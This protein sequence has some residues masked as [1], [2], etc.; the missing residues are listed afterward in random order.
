M[1]EPST[2][3]EWAPHPRRDTPRALALARELDAPLAAAHVLVNRGLCDGAA[4]RR[5]LEPELDDLHDPFQMLDLE[6]AVGRIQRALAAGERI[7]VHGDYDVDGMTGTSLLT[8]WI[9]RLGGRVVPFLPHRIR[10]G[11]DRGNAGL[12]TARA[13]GA[14][15]L[16]TVDCGVLAFDALERVYAGCEDDKLRGS[17]VFW[18]GQTDEAR[19][20]T[21]LTRALREDRSGEVREQIVFAISQLE[22]PAAVDALIELARNDGD[23][24]VRS[25][26]LFWLAQMAGEK[27]K[28][29]I[30][31]AAIDDPDPVMVFEH[32][33][34]YKMKGDVP[35]EAYRVPIGKAVV[36]RE[37]RDA[38][39]VATSIMVH[40][41]LEAAE[42]LAAQEP[43]RAFAALEGALAAVW[44]DGQIDHCVGSFPNI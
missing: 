31:D 25:R 42:A 11:Y 7:F 22:S 13:A 6:R 17:L 15:L 1:S 27:A 8:R 4:A 19:A 10:D 2:A 29:A 23:A 36:R 18:I 44:I 28:D 33:L 16:V 38:T 5:F 24:E 12:E 35:E 3:P 37:G 9:R 21:F 41:A 34:L 30:K 39:I 40:K 14:S 26:A 32:K 43:G 20:V